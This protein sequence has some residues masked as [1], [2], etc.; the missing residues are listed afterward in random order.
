MVELVSIF[1]GYDYYEKII[2]ASLGEKV[3]FSPV[4]EK[5]V[6]NASKL[7]LAEK[8]GIIIN[9]INENEKSPDIFDVSFDYKIGDH[10]NKFRIGP[11]RIGQVIVKRESLDACFDLLN[12]VMEKVHVEVKESE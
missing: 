3:D 8:S 9:M 4:N 7:I 10:V 1:Y 6:P 12:E 2:R 5:R 11:D